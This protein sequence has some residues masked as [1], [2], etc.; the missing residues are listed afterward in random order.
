MSAASYLNQIASVM[1]RIGKDQLDSIRQAGGW[2]ADSIA[3]GRLVYIF[4]SGH[5]VIPALDVFPR[6]GSF[7]GL[8]PILDPRLMWFNILGPGGVRELL[9][10]ERQE[11]YARVIL[12][13]YILDPRDTLIVFS[14]GGL[15]AAPLE[16]AQEAKRRGL[17][18]IGVTSLANRRDSRPIHSSGLSLADVADVVIDNCVLPEDALVTIP[19][20]REKVA[21]GSTVAGVAIMMALVAEAGA[22]LAERNVPLMIFVSPN[23]PGFPPD[24][25]GTVF[26]RYRQH[27]LDMQQAPAVRDSRAGKAGQ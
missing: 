24:H 18:V 22:R 17:R 25:N 14:H 9:W 12:Q 5:S 21:A 10:L 16:M 26:E 2:M 20:H 23:T 7:V 8:Q 11:G 3:Q 6:Y 27:T 1:D 13:S 15:N 19:G 4:G